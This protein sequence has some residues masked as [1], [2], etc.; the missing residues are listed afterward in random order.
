MTG[1]PPVVELP[2]LWEA[3]LDLEAAVGRRRE[4]YRRLDPLYRRI[5]SLDVGCWYCLRG[6]A[7][8]WDHVPAISI[9]DIEG[10]DPWA[11]HCVK[12]PVCEACN[13]V[14]GWLP[15]LTLPD[16]LRF[17]LGYAH[18]LA[19][20]CR[21]AVFS[22]PF[23]AREEA[24][25]AR[26]GFFE[27]WAVDFERKAV[28]AREELEYHDNHARF[29]GTRRVGYVPIRKRGEYRLVYSARD[30]A[31]F[32]YKRF[33]YFEPEFVAGPFYSVGEVKDAAVRLWPRPSWSGREH[34]RSGGKFDGN[35]I[36]DGQTGSR[37]ELV[38]LG[39]CM[40]LKNVLNRK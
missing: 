29:L 16:R 36:P 6:Q 30:G 5:G 22:E 11:H 1:A 18:R 10:R 40:S 15:L 39:D 4:R 13:R 8:A 26:A 7:V 28:I 14:L 38:S 31:L 19:A 3:P 20:E 32:L 9:V 37:D 12:V 21:E 2:V 23:G 35:G 17:L 24:M 33:R 27:S 25:R 34:V